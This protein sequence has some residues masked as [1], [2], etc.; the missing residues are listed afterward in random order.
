MEEVEGAGVPP[1]VEVPPDRTLGREVL[2]Q[3]ALLAPGPQ[4]V[5]DGVDH[6]PQVGR[7]GP[8]AGVDGQVRLDQRPLLVGDVTGVELGS[9]GPFYAPHHPL[10]DSHS[11]SSSV[12]TRRIAN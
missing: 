1:D 5:K 4:E 7:A 12:P 6:V 10:W 9:H 3:V 2:G 8:P 11:V